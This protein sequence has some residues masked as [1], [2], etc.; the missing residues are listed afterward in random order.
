MHLAPPKPPTTSSVCSLDD[1]LLDDRLFVIFGIGEDD[2]VLDNLRG[3]KP[4]ADHSRRNAADDRI[5]RNVLRH[6]RA[7]R[8]DRAASNRNSSYNNGTMSDPDIVFNDSCVRVTA[9]GVPDGLSNKI[10][11][12]IVATD[13]C[14]IPTDQDLT[15][16]RGVALDGAAASKLNVVPEHY[17]P[18]GREKPYVHRAAYVF[19]V[20]DPVVKH[21]E[22]DGTANT[23]GNPPEAKSNH[24]RRRFDACKLPT[25]QPSSGVCKY[26]WPQHGRVLTLASNGS[27]LSCSRLQ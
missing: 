3:R 6:D 9:A 21:V 12:M 8:D 25:D 26:D 17:F 24:W 20:A 7:C 16:E 11:S 15:A 27:S 5:P 13:K 2:F 1:E 23:I 14:D 4:H 19:P 18:T 10:D 22:L